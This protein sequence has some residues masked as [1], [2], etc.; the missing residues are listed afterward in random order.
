M[1]LCLFWPYLAVCLFRFV[2]IDQKFHMFM[3]CKHFKCTMHLAMMT[4]STWHQWHMSYV[5]EVMTDFHHTTEVEVII[6]DALAWPADLTGPM[7]CV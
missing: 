3:D 6:V 5:E 1:L 4:W 7:L 2:S